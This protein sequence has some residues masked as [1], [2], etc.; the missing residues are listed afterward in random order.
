LIKS[1]FISRDKNNC[2][3][4]VEFCKD[5][6]LNLTAQSLIYFEPT[7]FEL[8]GSYN[9]I[10]FSSIRSADFFLQ[11]HQIADTK[12]IAC[13]GQET[14]NKLNN[15]GINVDFIGSNPSNPSEVAV[16]F[17]KWLG[18][19]N[20]LIPHSS[21]SLLSITENLNFDQIKLVEVYKTRLK[22]LEI[23]PCDCYIFT[24]PSNVRSFQMANDLSN[25]KNVIAWGASTEKALASKK[26]PVMKVL[27]TGTMN[28]LENYLIKLI[29]S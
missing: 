3:S 5:Q 4:L 22:P 14:A 19:R 21:V 15:L 9:V 7:D 26:I 2:E 10:F 28:E 29:L 13:I 24:S 1:I 12:Q 17:K 25:L 16:E 8:A 18:T 23:E 20:V 6:N 27:Q 11:K